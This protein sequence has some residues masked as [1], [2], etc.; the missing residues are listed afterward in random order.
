MGWL[1]SL[2]VAAVTGVTTM[3]VAG[4][5]ATLV[6]EWYR[7]SSFEGQSGYFVVAM[8]FL[9]LLG[10]LLVGVVTARMLAGDEP[11]ALRALGLAHLLA[12]GPVVLVSG[13]AWLL[14]DIPPRLDGEELHLAVEFQWPEGTGPAGAPD[15]AGWFVRLGAASGRT[16]RASREG[17][18]WREDARLENGR[19][20]V[21]GAVEIFTRR[22]RR[23]LAVTPPEV[24]GSGFI[25]PLP[26]RPGPQFREW[27]EWLPRVTAPD[28]APAGGFRYR[29]RVV[30]RNQPIRVETFGE[31]EVETI[32]SHFG[33]WR[34]DGAA[35]TWMASARF[36]VRHRGRPVEAEHPS[37]DQSLPRRVDRFDA[38]AAVPGPRPALVLRV[39]DY[40]QSGI[41]LL[42]RE[43][44]A[45]ELRV[46]PVAPCSG[47]LQGILLTADP[48]APIARRDG[49]APSGH[50][51]RSSFAAAGLYFFQGAVL[52]TRDLS[53]RRFSPEHLDRWTGQVPP[54]G[55]SPD[56]SS[57]VG[58]AEG[59]SPDQPALHVLD[60]DRDSA[61]VLP[62][63][64]SRMRYISFDRI[65]GRWVQHH[66]AWIRDNRGRD[67]LVE[68]PN[69]TPMPW[70]GTLTLDP[71]GY[72]EY[73]LAPA[74]EE[75]RSALIDFL[76]TEFEAERLP[77]PGSDYL[78]QVRIGEVVVSL[79]W[80]PSGARVS[81]WLDR[82]TD[83]R[84]VETIAERFDGVL[85]AG[86]HDDLFGR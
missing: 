21:P 85:R 2:A 79:G 18:L 72:R 81:A 59:D 86:R 32:A 52:D 42:A 22:G 77:E 6:V 11:G 73:R 17:P 76:V 51:D 63:D 4:W 65:D 55:G 36:A 41:C 71:D 19:W 37:A 28:S 49:A 38:V 15:S 1:A 61:Y 70:Q 29:F 14:A 80:D 16:V 69:F 75:L 35:P 74:R 44:E 25:V 60:L 43:D 64:A 48:G 62:I 30:P 10:G 66:F 13:T 8:A 47:P 78:R 84:L 24:I 54:L 33:T 82:G 58:L 67:R 56:G 45:A 53:L 57:I 46:E 39:D 50:F 7:I 34:L 20:V 9:G 68:R 23:L 3:L 40:W 27:S 31:F 26:G 83:R 12:L 5:A